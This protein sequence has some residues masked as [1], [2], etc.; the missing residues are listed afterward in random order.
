MATVSWGT[1]QGRDGMR[2][3][4]FCPDRSII[5]F[6][7]FCNM[8][9]VPSWI[10]ILLFWTTHE[11]NHAVWLPCQNFVWIRSLPSE[12]LWF[13]DFASLPNH[14]PFWGF[15]VGLKPLKLW[16]VIRSPKGTSLGEEA[17]FKPQTV[18]IR[19]GCNLG[20]IPRTKYNHDRTIKKSQNRNISHIWG[21]NSRWQT[22][23][24]LKIIYWP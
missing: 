6:P 3:P 20:T 1:C 19:P 15:L 21:K 23:A 17:S 24:I 4:K 22:A 7:T 16:V 8:A 10:G 14:A 12:I 13:Y 2:P 9:A 5:A 11:V 18:K